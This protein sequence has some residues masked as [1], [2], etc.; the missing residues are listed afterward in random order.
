MLFIML[1]TS[2]N[3]IIK[4][5]LVGNNNFICFLPCKQL[6][7]STTISKLLQNVPRLWKS[8]NDVTV[9]KMNVTPM[10]TASFRIKNNLKINTISNYIVLKQV[11]VLFR[12]ICLKYVL[13]MAVIDRKALKTL[14]LSYTASC[15]LYSAS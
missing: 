8:T 1:K 4:G 3:R 9:S 11:H 10:I 7:Q 2:Y 15:I 6:I 13:Q 12:L 14:K 5:W